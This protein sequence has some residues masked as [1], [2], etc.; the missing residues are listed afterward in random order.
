MAWAYDSASHNSN[1]FKAAS[2]SKDTSTFTISPAANTTA[3]DRVFLYIGA[4]HRAGAAPTVSSITDPRSNS[5]H[6]DAYHTFTDSSDNGFVAIWSAQIATQILS[7]DTLTVNL[8]STARKSGLML[9]EYSGLDTSTTPVDVSA[10]NGVTSSNAT[11]TSGTTPA[12]G[13]ANELVIRVYGDDGWNIA[14]GTAPAGTVEINGM[15]SG[16][17]SQWWSDQNSG[18]SGATATL[19]GT[20]ASATTWA[21]ATVVY[22][23]AGAAVVF[24]PPPIVTSL[25]AV[26]RS[27]NF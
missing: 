1:T 20:M 27:A 19:S 18:S 22:K 5:W 14:W 7:T 23:L 17:W 11:V 16:S 4:I 13:A 6:Q 24:Q 10:S 3:G 25:Q 2:S 26:N 15:P 12:T 8:S 9:L 21:C